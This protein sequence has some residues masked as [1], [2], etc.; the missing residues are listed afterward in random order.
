MVTVS[1]RDACWVMEPREI[2]DLTEIFDEACHR[3]MT[4][5]DSEAGQMIAKR[6][7]AAV[8]SGIKD[9]DKLLRLVTAKTAA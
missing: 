5:R 8:H 2:A 4:A 6:L 1:N 9:R 7:L 3:T